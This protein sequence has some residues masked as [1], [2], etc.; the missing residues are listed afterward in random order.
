MTCLQAHTKVQARPVRRVPRL[1]LQHAGKCSAHARQ[2]RR[3]PRTFNCRLANQLLQTRSLLQAQ[4]FAACTAAGC[5]RRRTRRA[6]HRAH[7]LHVGPAGGVLLRNLRLQ[8][9]VRP[10]LRQRM[11]DVL[12]RAPPAKASISL[13]TYGQGPLLGYDQMK[14]RLHFPSTDHI[15]QTALL[16]TIC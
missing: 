4:I 6:T 5:D 1:F 15:D 13:K 2:R 11:Q 8:R 16:V 7:A 9:G 14:T 10:W 12:L 3:V